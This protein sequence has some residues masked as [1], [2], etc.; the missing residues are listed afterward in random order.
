[1]HTAFIA[2]YPQ[3]GIQW[4]LF[5]NSPPWT[6]PLSVLLTLGFF[7]F[8]FANKFSFSVWAPSVF[9]FFC[10]LLFLNTPL[11]FKK[12]ISLTALTP[13]IHSQE[14]GLLTTNMPVNVKT[15]NP[16][17]WDRLSVQ[18]FFYRKGL[19]THANSLIVYDIAKRFS[20]FSTDYGID[21][22]AGPQASVVFEIYGNDKLLFRSDVMKRFDYPKH[23][24][25]DITGVSQLKLIVTDSG[26]GNIDDHADWLNPLLFP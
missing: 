16:K 20:K 17:T 6:I 1:M 19:G 25:A 9:I 23:A 13:P 12:P 11:L 18:Y 10:S 8:L 2:N 22:E 7:F 14:F 5:L 24:E 26:N 21:T 4:L 15:G 3:N